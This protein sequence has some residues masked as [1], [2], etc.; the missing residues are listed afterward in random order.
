MFLILI[1]TSIFS[2][3]F[4]GFGNDNFVHELFAQIPDN[5]FGAIL[6]VILLIFVLNF[7]LDFIE[8]TFVIIPIMAPILLTMG[9]DPV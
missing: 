7:I 4:H 9:L 6:M 2:L 1:D 3:V 5:T 8:I